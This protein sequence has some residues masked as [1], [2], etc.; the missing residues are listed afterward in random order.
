MAA[1][2]RHY[3]FVGM[4]KAKST[5]GTI[6]LVM[7]SC[8]LVGFA[9]KVG[10]FGGVVTNLRDPVT[11]GDVGV[12]EL[13]ALGGTGGGQFQDTCL[14]GGMLRG[15]ELRTGDDVD[16]IRPF[17]VLSIENSHL[18]PD[19]TESLL[20]PWHGGGGGGAQWLLCPL[21]TPIVLGMDIGAE[22][23]NTIVVKTIHLFC[24]RVVAAQTAAAYPSAI[25]DGPP[26]HATASVL[27]IGGDSIHDTGGSER[28]PSGKVAVGMHGRSGIYL[29]AIGLVCDAATNF[30]PHVTGTA[31]GRVP[32]PASSPPLSVCEAAKGARARNS[33]AAASLEA[34]CRSQHTPE[35]AMEQATQHGISPGG[36]LNW[37]QTTPNAV[38][39]HGITTGVFN[40]TMAPRS[41]EPAVPTGS[42]AA[43]SAAATPVTRATVST[44]VV[45]PASGARAAIAPPTNAAA[46]VSQG[47]AQM[48]AG[49]VWAAPGAAAVSSA[50]PS[51]R[52]PCLRPV[53]SGAGLQAATNHAG[54]SVAGGNSTRPCKAEEMGNPQESGQAAGLKPSH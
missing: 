42:R 29:D 26:D 8:L 32:V 3:C 39:I 44:A 30:V 45:A 4:N 25:F 2:A 36:H 46:A 19:P 13:P 6:R 11:L 14:T 43:V 9:S 20:G 48:P 23:V 17:C 40:P 22:G 15:F 47:A 38:G 37:S 34:Q 10:A 21:S 31:L 7:M 41:I 27:G 52:L 51:V 50:A 16:A 53:T 24:G 54:I 12:V 18:T 33:P 5:P 35:G 28:C 49:R 1:F